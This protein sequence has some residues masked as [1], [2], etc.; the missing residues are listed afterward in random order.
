[1]AAQKE[2]T[3]T[4][5][6]AKEDLAARM[7][8]VQL[9]SRVAELLLKVTTLSRELLEEKKKSLKL[10][11]ELINKPGKGHQQAPPQPEQYESTKHRQKNSDLRG[12]RLMAQQVAKFCPE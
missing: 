5:I 10:Y 9:D 8:P 6:K 12:M 11:E 1:V 7:G 4:A 2:L 3:N